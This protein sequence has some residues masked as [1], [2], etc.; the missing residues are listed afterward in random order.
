MVRQAPEKA[1]S[2]I[3]RL[4]DSYLNYYV[5]RIVHFLKR[6][7]R[8]T[9]RATIDSKNQVTRHEGS[10]LEQFYLLIRAPGTI[11]TECWLEPKMMVPCHA[12][13]TCATFQGDRQVVVKKRK[14]L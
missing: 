5:S 13:L 3:M 11:A 4:F 8:C 2:C 9:S 10:D 12:I 6:E 7:V 1:L 14:Q